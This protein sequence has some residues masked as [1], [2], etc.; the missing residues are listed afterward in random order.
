[1]ESSQAVKMGQFWQKF[2]TVYKRNFSFYIIH[3]LYEI[4]K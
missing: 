4:L 1:M 2:L 3:L